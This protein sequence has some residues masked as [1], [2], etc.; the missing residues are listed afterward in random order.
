MNNQIAA[1]DGDK[2]KIVVISGG[3]SWDTYEEYITYL[4]EK[5]Y[6]PYE[7]YGEGWKKLLQDALGE[8]YD[9]IYVMMPSRANAK[10]DEWVIWF[11]KLLPYI[12][13]DVRFVGHSLGAN[14]LAKYLSENT[15]DASIT[16]V[17]FV[18][19]SFGTKGGFNLP[20]SLDKIEKQCDDIY[21][22][23]STDDHIVEFMNG[24]KYHVALPTATFVT[25]D[26]RNHFLQDKFPEIVKN[27]KRSK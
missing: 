9:V 5:K 22:Y 7:N 10:Y 8:V 21:I 14:F 3:E 2:K 6:D 4:K 12:Q 13:M 16:Q 23:H 1:Q 19:G 25:F 27:I 11:E 24:E 17:H 18:A 20:Q 15:L 26:D